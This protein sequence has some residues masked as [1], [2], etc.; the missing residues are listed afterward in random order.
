MRVINARNVNDAYAAGCQLVR[1]CGVPSSSRDGDVRVV[2]FPVVTEY[3]FPR[4][5]VLVDEHRK[6]NPFFHLMEALWMLAGRRDARW[7]D[8][9]VKGF[10]S[11]FAESDGNQ[12]GAY[13]YRWRHHF[14]LDGGGHPGLPDQLDTVVRLLRTNPK[15][16]RVVITMWDPVADLGSLV[17]DVPCNTHIYPRV[18][19]I[20]AGGPSVL[21]IT[22]C[23]RSNDIFMGA[24]GANAVHFSILQEYLAARIGVE[25]GTYYQF[26]NN[27]HAYQRDLD[28]FQQ[29][30]VFMAR[31]NHFYTQHRPMRLV[32]NPATFDDEL[33]ALLAGHSVDVHNH[34]LALVAMPMCMANF[35]RRH[36]DRDEA[37]RILAGAPQDVDWIQAGRLFIERTMRD[38]RE[39]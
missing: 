36:G 18:R 34:F 4:E 33:I 7:L 5:R 15:D 27:F 10:S 38:D 14:D 1:E 26:S 12:H 31:E 9:F 3:V 24:Y 35:S 17:R 28:R 16:R 19:D 39:G 8:Q 37:L 32:D 30:S 13:G 6:A 22:V 21:D 25:V 2:P 11:R 29:P 20:A 23:C